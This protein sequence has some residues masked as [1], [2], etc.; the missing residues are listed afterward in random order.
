MDVYKLEG[1]CR[2]FTTYS[3]VKLPIKLM[4]PINVSATENRN[5]YFIG[6][7]DQNERM[8]GFQKMVYGEIEMQHKYTF[9]QEGVLTQ[10]EIMDAEQEVTVL[11][12]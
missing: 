12:F 7:F 3:G 5:T 9:N 8:T 4:Q 1:V 11:N 6:Y 2:Y 10:A